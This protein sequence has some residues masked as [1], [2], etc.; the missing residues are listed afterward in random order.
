MNSNEPV[1]I[2]LIDKGMPFNLDTPYNAPLGG[3]ETSLLLLS[4]GIAETDN[5]SI[6]LSTTNTNVPEDDYN[7][8]LHNIN[9]LPQILPD[10]DV[11][12][13]NRCIIED[14]LYSNK[15]IFYYNHDA[16]DQNHIVGWMVDKKLL[17]RIEK[18]LC[19][20]EWQRQTFHKYMNVPLEKMIVIGNCIDP[21]LSYG[22][23]E[24]NINKLI[25]S[26][27]PYKGLD[28]IGNIFS[29][30]CIKGKR[31]D[32]ELHVFSSM[33]LYGNQ[34]GDKEYEQIFAS[35]GKIKGVHIYPAVSMK[36]LSTE[37]LSSS[38]ILFPN[39]YH[40]TFSM[41]CTQAQ[42]A[43][44]VPIS[45]NIGAMCERIENGVSGF[46]TKTPNILHSETYNEFIDLACNALNSDLYK[47][48]LNCQ[49][50]AAKYSYLNV[51]KRL[52]EAIHN[53]CNSKSKK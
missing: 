16:Y 4:K 18:I 42:A 34:E 30:I 35:L 32:L 5:S 53:V 36:Q 22:Y 8:I 48:R 15:R 38:L 52:L 11:V 12:I 27:I 51:A 9:I 10:A 45:T 33:G 29:D 23:V 3:S 43:G 21:T 20:S 39:T 31:D 7:R 19:V 24:R 14:V 2:L 49:K 44:C 37:F 25:F 6:I 28:V 47:M 50:I 17:N 40:E 46:L 13:F 26:C 1:K 41:N